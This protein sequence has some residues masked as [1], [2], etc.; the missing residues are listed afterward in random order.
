MQSNKF[1]EQSEDSNI[2][3]NLKFEAVPGMGIVTPMSVD[4]DQ[5]KWSIKINNPLAPISEEINE[6]SPSKVNRKNVDFSS[7][8][9]SDS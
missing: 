3:S 2:P 8:V 7:Y 1:D 9:V 4:F 6:A 5:P